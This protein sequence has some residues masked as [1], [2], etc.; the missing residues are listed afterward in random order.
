MICSYFQQ[1]YVK[2]AIDK[3]T[4]LTCQGI[5][6]R[7]VY[8]NIYTCLGR[9]WRPRL[10]N[11]QTSQY[12]DERLLCVRILVHLIDMLLQVI[13]SCPLLQR[14]GCASHA[15]TIDVWFRNIY[16]YL[17]HDITRCCCIPMRASAALGNDVST[18]LQYGTCS[19]PTG[20]K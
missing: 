20:L 15:S 12:P 18:M 5:R 3:I 14:S 6:C 9:P 17:E 7:L 2:S 11:N 13:A 10:I 8:H 4:L 16:C 19:A 1:R